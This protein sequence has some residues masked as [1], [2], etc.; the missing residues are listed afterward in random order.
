LYVA[1]QPISCARLMFLV[2]LSAGVITLVTILRCAGRGVKCILDVVRP[3][4]VGLELNWCDAARVSQEGTP[5]YAHDKK[6]DDEM[7]TKLSRREFLKA[8]GLTTALAVLAACAPKATPEPTKPPEQKAEPTKPPA[9][10]PAPAKKVKIRVHDLVAE[11]CT[12]PSCFDREIQKMFD[13]SHPNIEVEHLPFPSVTVEKRKEYWVTA[14]S[15]EGGPNVVFFDNNIFTLEMASMGNVAPLDEYLPLYY[16][17]WNDLFPIIQEVSMYNGKV[18]QIPGMV[19]VNGIAVRRDYLQEAGYDANFYPKDWPEWLEMCQKLTT[20]DHWGFQWPMIPWAFGCFLAMDGGTVALEKE[21][22]TIELHFTDKEVVETAQMFKDCVFKYK[23]TGPDTFS[24]F[25]TNLNNFQ[26]GKAA[27]FNF[28]PSWLNWL[29]GQAKFQPEQL[30]FAPY[31]FGPSAINKNS[32]IKPY[33]GVGTHSWAISAKQPKDE[34]DAAAQYICYIRSKAMIKK[35][36]EWWKA[37]ELKGV[38]A[39]PFKDVPWN[40]VSSG[41]PEWWGQPLLTILEYGGKSPAPDYRGADYLEKALQE[42]LRTEDS[43]IKAELQKGEDR[44]RRE[45][46]DEYH[47][48]LQG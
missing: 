30:N 1:L 36:A 11:D 21:D 28:M 32:L 40:T 45:F 18:Y 46:L 9:A 4:E 10:T 43:D 38:Y 6:E 23:V 2:V 41:V 14:L 22:R 16:P 29:F 3:K 15:T 12:G 34:M 20:A 44:A 8:A 26:Q 39:S 33:T 5:E 19:E 7:A 47:K 48:Q 42:I 24:D 31:P 25:A 17:E 13:E 27:T 37:N 35:Q